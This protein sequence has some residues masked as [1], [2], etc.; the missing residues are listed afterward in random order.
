MRKGGLDIQQARAKNIALLAKLNWRIFHEKDSLWVK[1][2]LNKYWS[3]A[4]RNSRDPGKL[5]CSSVWTAIKVGFPV[6]EKGVC[7]NARTNSKLQF[8]G[9]KWMKVGSVRELIEGPLTQSKTELTVANV[10]QEGRWCWEKLSFD[11][12]KEVLEKILA[13]PMQMYGEK[14]DSFI[15]KYSQNGEFNNASAYNLARNDGTI[16][17]AFSGYWLWKLDTIPKIQHFIW[18]CFHNSV[19]V[20]KIFVDRGIPCSTACPFCQ[21]QEESIIHLLRDCP[22]A[23]NFWKQLGVPQ[24]FANFLCLNLPDWF[25]QSCLC[26]NQVLA[27]GFSWNVQFP[28]AIWCLWRHR[29]NVVFDNAPANPNLHLMCIQLAREFF[30]CVSKRQKTRH[31]TVNPVCWLKPNHGWY[32]L[33]SDGT[34]KEIVVENNFNIERLELEASNLFS[35]YINEL[36]LQ[37]NLN[38]LPFKNL[39]NFSLNTPNVTEKW[40]EEHLYGL[41]TPRELT[42]IIVL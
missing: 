30:Y 22:F 35:L 42:S 29:N 7:W 17:S 40:L 10:F 1:T 12:P 6:F 37:C 34:V 2:I 33:N 38:L 28:F 32:K 14:E 26:S 31:C 21:N 16:P 20:W 41:P 36:K 15:W 13:V 24:I 5:P 25:K 8:W 4:R 9:S 19:P 39:K 3:R 18:L 27:N 23:L 11:L